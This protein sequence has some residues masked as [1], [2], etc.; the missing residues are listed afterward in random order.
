[1]ILFDRF[2]SGINS[3]L[4]KGKKSSY[5]THLAMGGV[6]AGRDS[7]VNLKTKESKQRKNL[8]RKINLYRSQKK[9]PSS[10]S[11]KESPGKNWRRLVLLIICLCVAIG[12]FFNSAGLKN[13]RFILEDLTYFHITGVEVKGSVRAASEKIR[14]S[15]GILLRSSLFFLDDEKIS[16]AVRSKNHWVDEVEIHRKWPDEV[17]VQ[18]KEFVPVALIGVAA[19]EGTD[20]Y[21]MDKKG[22]PFVKATAGMDLD[23]PVMTGLELTE[24]SEK[25]VQLEEALTFLTLIRKNNPNLPSQSVSELHVDRSEGLIIHMVE[26]PFPIFFGNGDI[27][28]KYF[29]LRKVLE[30]LY[31]YKPGENVMGIADVAYIRMDYLDNKVLVGYRRNIESG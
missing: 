27:R 20:L 13:V 28:K 4:G 5:G 14:N 9:A 26:H 18:V 10:Q 29:K 25:L 2:K 22:K 16:K 15:S 11:F 1:M 7:F 24:T 19:G 21:Y 12:L 23:F 17:V 3:L 8:L 6:D 30:K 31:K